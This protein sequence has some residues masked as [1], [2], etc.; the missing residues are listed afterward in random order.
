MNSIDSST[1]RPAGKL[2]FFM[3]IKT[4]GLFDSFQF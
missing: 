3:K 1:E 2:D 4:K